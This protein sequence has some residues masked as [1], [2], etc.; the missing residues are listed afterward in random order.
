MKLMRPRLDYDCA[1]SVAVKR[2]KTTNQRLRRPISQ[3]QE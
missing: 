3:R 2:G 1:E